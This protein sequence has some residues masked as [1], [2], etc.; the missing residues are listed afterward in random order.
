MELSRDID[1]ILLAEF[2][3]REGFNPIGI[4]R[5]EWPSG[6]VRVHSGNGDLQWQGETWQGVAKI[7]SLEIEPE[8][9]GLAP[10]EA[11]MSLLGPVE[12]LLA[13]MDPAARGGLVQMWIGATTRPGGTDLIGTP[14]PAFTGRI[15]SNEV[16]LPGEK[17]GALEVKVKG[18]PGAREAGAAYH[19]DEDQKARA[20][21]DTIFE[22][23][24]WAATWRDNPPLFPAP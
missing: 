8:R 16:T 1:P 3:K 22:R 7:A 9:E 20:P 24:G 5:S 15:V 13:E 2:A 19:S 4:I 11:A 6:E 17:A 18:G 10:A 14:F 23:L 12:D 21:G